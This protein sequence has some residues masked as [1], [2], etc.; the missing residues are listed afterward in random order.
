MKCPFLWLL[1]LGP[2]GFRVERLCRFGNFEDVPWTEAI[3]NLQHPWL[4]WLYGQLILE[5]DTDAELGAP[6]GV[7]FLF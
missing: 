6:E 5:Q 3:Y 2:S 1:L 4:Q 7:A